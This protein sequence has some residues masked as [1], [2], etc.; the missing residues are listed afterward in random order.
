MRQFN[1]REFQ[2]ILGNNG[3]E[4]KRKKGD[5]LIYSKEG[6]T[7]IAITATRLNAC[8]ALRLIKENKLVIDN[9]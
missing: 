4:L 7:S 8:V 1:V 3:Y 9:R 6:K 5:H 2:S